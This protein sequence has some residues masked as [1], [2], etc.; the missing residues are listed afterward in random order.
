M[1]TD[2]LLWLGCHMKEI[3]FDKMYISYIFF[4]N[5]ECFYDFCTDYKKVI[6]F[7]LY[8]NSFR[9]QLIMSTEKKCFPSCI[10]SLGVVLIHVSKSHFIACKIETRTMDSTLSWN[11]IL[12]KILLSY[13]LILSMIFGK[14]Y[15]W[16]CVIE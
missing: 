3:S 4:A 7:R 1:C 10:A 11:M 14:S 2:F 16:L 12:L 9:C 5:V 15:Q 8:I 6:S 13:L